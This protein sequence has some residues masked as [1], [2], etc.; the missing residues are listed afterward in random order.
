M[1]DLV[2]G[3]TFAA[4]IGSGAIGG[5]FFAFSSFIMKSLGRIPAPEG[6]RAMQSINI[7]V[8]TPWFMAPFFGTALLSIALAIIAGLELEKSHAPYL[9]G[10]A[11]L[12]LVGTMVITIAGNVPLNNELAA[13]DADS[14]E[15][16]EVWARYVFRWTAL[17]TLR[18]GA[19]LAASVAFIVAL[20][21]S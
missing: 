4:A 7:V 2:F 3:L 15:G 17:N 8:I 14:A 6:M 21:V 9:L 5:A 18:T 12:Y 19:A 20:L 10:G 11:A 13:T 16:R 1:N